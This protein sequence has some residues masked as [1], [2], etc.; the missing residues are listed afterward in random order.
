LT[1]LIRG[2]I[3]QGVGQFLFVAPGSIIHRRW[4]IP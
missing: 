4:Q 1:E 3:R 2:I